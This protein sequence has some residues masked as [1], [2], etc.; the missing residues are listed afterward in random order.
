M[1][2]VTGLDHLNLSVGLDLSWGWV[3]VGQGRDP[4]FVPADAEDPLGKLSE[5]LAADL[6]SR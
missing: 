2:S 3:A 6:A 5:Y 4:I 1:A